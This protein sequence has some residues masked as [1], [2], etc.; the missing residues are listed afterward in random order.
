MNSRWLFDTPKRFSPN[1]AV[2]GA[3][4]LSSG[5]IAGCG[6][7]KKNIPGLDGVN[8]GVFD[9]HLVAS[10][11]SQTFKTD[12]GASFPIPGLKDAMLS[13]QPDLASAGTVFQISVGIDSL[14][15]GEMHHEPQ[16]LP[17]GGALPEVV[18]GAL[19]RWDTMLGKLPISLYLS[20]EVFG[21]FIQLKFMDSKGFIL[22]WIVSTV[23]RDDRGNQLGKAYAIPENVSGSSGLLILLPYFS[24][25]EAG[26]N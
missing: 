14:G 5:F 2:L 25:K 1:L 23:I 12:V 20:D 4:L 9:R 13:V 6:K 17:G 7:G 19:P 24:P 18:G 16:G 22:P 11:V 8:I 26:K 21:I 15:G 3:L 10:F